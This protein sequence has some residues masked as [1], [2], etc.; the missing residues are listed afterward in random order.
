MRLAT[1]TSPY[2]YCLC[3]VRCSCELD[4]CALVLHWLEMAQ[5]NKPTPHFHS[6]TYHHSYKHSSPDTTR[7]TQ[8]PMPLQRVAGEGR[9]HLPTLRHPARVH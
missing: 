9:H 2:L 7:K 1:C 4:W 8:N 5:L 6:S 3:T